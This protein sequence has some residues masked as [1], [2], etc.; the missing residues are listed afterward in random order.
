[1]SNNLNDWMIKEPIKCNRYR[2]WELFPGSVFTIS[3]T[4]GPTP[5]KVMEQKGT[6]TKCETGDETTF[7]DA[8][9][10]VVYIATEET[11][12]E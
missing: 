7:L 10:E 5:L 4:P 2:L 6:L 9:L 1:M 3:T 11:V 12:T 8:S